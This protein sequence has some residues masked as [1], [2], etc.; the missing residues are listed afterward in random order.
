[1][2]EIDYDATINDRPQMKQFDKPR[3]V[4]HERPKPREDEPLENS[5]ADLGEQLI[6]GKEAARRGIAV[7]LEVPL[8]PR[9]DLVNALADRLG[10]FGD[11]CV[12]KW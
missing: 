7:E 10:Q 1:M 2:T 5:N 9:E 6:F 4:V 11:E 12:C 8:R 3:V